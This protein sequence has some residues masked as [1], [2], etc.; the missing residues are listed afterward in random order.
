MQTVQIELNGAEIWSSLDFQTGDAEAKARQLYEL[1]DE[2]ADAMETSSDASATITAAEIAAIKTTVERPAEI[3]EAI[4]DAHIAYLNKTTE[5][6]SAG[7]FTHAA[8]GESGFTDRDALLEAAGRLEAAA[9]AI[10]AAEASSASV[11]ELYREVYDQLVL[12]FTDLSVEPLELSQVYFAAINETNDTVGDE[13]GRLTSDGRLGNIA[14]LRANNSYR[15]YLYDPETPA[16]GS[17]GFHTETRSEETALPSIL[18]VPVTDEPDSDGDGLIDQAEFVIGTKPNVA[19]TDE[20]GTNDGDEVAAG[21]DPLSVEISI[22]DNISTT[23]TTE[24]EVDRY[25]FT[26]PPGASVYFDS[27]S[28]DGLSSA[29][30][31]LTDAAGNEI[32]DSCLGCTEAGVQILEAGGPY[33]LTVGSTTGSQIG[34]YQIQ[35]WSVPAPDIFDIALN[36]VLSST[37]P[38]DGSGNIESPGVKDI[39]RFSGSAGQEIFVDIQEQNGIS[40]IDWNLVDS[41]GTE[42]FNTCLG[43]TQPGLFTLEVSGTFSL[44]VGDDRDDGVGTYRIQV[45]DVPAP[46]EFNIT[47]GDVISTTQ[48]G[49]GSGTIESPGVKDIYRFT[50]TAGQ[51]IY[52]DNQGQ[53]GVSQVDWTI[54]D[55]AGT[56]IFRTCLGCTEPGL[57]ALDLGGPYTLTVGDTRDDGVGTYRVQLW[58]VPEP[59]RFTISIGD[60]VSPGVPDSGAGTIESP[61]TSDIYSFDG[62][63]G[64]TINIIHSSLDGVGQIDIEL[65]TPTGTSIDSTCL[66]CTDLGN[67]TLPET[68][69]YT[70]VIGDTR[71]DGFGTYQF[72]VTNSP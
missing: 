4:L 34:S 24:G 3:T 62:T 42:Y 57:F 28:N 29:D 16:Y 55:S 49:G 59:D 13:R 67:I 6:W 54:V 40:Q 60:T 63:T 11:D 15:L 43:C 27:V 65:I 66:S 18:L 35:L 12:E 36:D 45:W 5:K 41:N 2:I 39:Y 22:G 53:S 7:I 10:L 38:G 71:D 31:R 1:Q 70:L 44:T 56:E 21:Q 69:T 61:G 17:A 8:A 58:N 52:V 26:A 19:D 72:S 68:G 47:I 23:I 9:E 50:A 25:I 32:F 14:S 46:D 51:E 48:P 20:D 64:Q 37:T 33:L 30:W